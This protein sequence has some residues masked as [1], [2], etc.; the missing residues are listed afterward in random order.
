[1]A[2]GERDDAVPIESAVALAEAFAGSGK[3]RVVFRRYPGLDHR[4]RDE[5]GEDRLREV[6]GEV[7]DWLAEIL[8]R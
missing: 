3:T 4:C 7:L 2:D 6:A 1:M 5:R 8:L